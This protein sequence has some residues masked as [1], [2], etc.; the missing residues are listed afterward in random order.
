MSMLPFLEHLRRCE[1]C[2]AMPRV[3]CEIGYDLFS[4]GAERLVRLID[5]KR[6]RA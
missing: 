1:V 3:P 6:A 5:P 4:R 2:R